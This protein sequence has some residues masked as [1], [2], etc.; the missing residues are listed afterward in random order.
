VKYFLAPG[1]PEICPKNDP[2]DFM[3]LRNLLSLQILMILWWTAGCV[4]SPSG[5]V[6]EIILISPP[7]F[8]GNLVQN[9]STPSLGVYNISG[10]CDNLSYGLEYSTDGGSTWTVHPPGCVAG[11]FSFNVTLVSGQ[12]TVLVKAK[13][14]YSYTV[15]GQAIVRVTPAPTS[16]HF[17]A[18]SSGGVTQSTIG[19]GIQGGIAP[20]LSRASLDG[21]TRKVKA[22]LIDAIYGP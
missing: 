1:V 16:P 4:E 8:M 19:L 20:S 22:D 9:Y 15:P 3:N 10:E 14:R 21:G 6:T 18:M 7:T 5:S 11:A 12:T 13:T 2:K 17:Q